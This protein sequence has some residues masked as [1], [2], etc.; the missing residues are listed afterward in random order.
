[1]R[2][3][4]K[5]GSLATA[6]W[7]LRSGLW[8]VACYPREK[9]PIG[10]AWAVTCPSR[11]RL[12]ATFEHHPGAGVGVALG[13]EAGLVDFEVDA[14]SEAAGLLPRLGLPPSLGW[15]S[16]RGEHRLFRW[17]NR[18][19]GVAV[20]AVA[21]F[22]GA[23]LRIGGV[24]KQ[25]VSV[26]PPSVGDNRRC[27]RWND[28][29]EIAPL[30]E[31]LLRELDRPMQRQARKVPLSTGN[32]RYGEAALRAE[33]RAVREARP[34]ARNSTL[35]CSAFCLGQLVAAGLLVRETVEA[36]LTD[37]ALYAGLG[38]RE[39][40]ATLN[41]GLEAGLLRPRERRG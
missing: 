22:D 38:E 40:A 33:A 24:G 39:I 18:L 2:P 31:S 26:C 15:R 19:E 32:C 17:D 14:P 6:L 9:R 34:G 8:P 13:P 7:M 36:E 37:A 25:L 41:S 4:P 1:M 21:H 27:R 35:N 11:D 30:P 3:A 5:R 29:W 10:P 16:A 12:L 28:I 20:S 23:E